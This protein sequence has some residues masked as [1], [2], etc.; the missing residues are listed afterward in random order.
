MPQLRFLAYNKTPLVIAFISLLAFIFD[1]QIATHFIYLKSAINQGEIWR[2]ITGHFLHTNGYHLLLNCIGLLLLY[3]VH[4]QY[5][6]AK[7]YLSL[8]L[9]CS[10]I[11]SAGIWWYTDINSYVG[12]SG[13]L[14]GIFVW[15][16]LKDIEHKEKTGY[17]LLIGIWCKVL[18]EQTFGADSNISELINAEVAIDAHLWGAIA[19]SLYFLIEK[20]LIKRH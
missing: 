5:Y 13:V 17:A 20:H 1:Q 18:Y 9:F 14:H 3:L 15:G 12:L 19:G 6:Q 16:A 11:T 8:L 4:G 10:F 7:S 2:L